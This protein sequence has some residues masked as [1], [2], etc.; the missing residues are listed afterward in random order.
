MILYRDLGRDLPYWRGAQLKRTLVASLDQLQMCKYKIFE[1]K[2]L[3]QEFTPLTCDPMRPLGW[4]RRCAILFV[5]CLTSNHCNAFL[6]SKSPQRRLCQGSIGQCSRLSAISQESTPTTTAGKAE[7][8]EYAPLASALWAFTRP[9]TIIGSALSI[10]ALH[11][12]ASPSG[13]P[14]FQTSHIL[15]L[16]FAWIPA[17]LLNIYIVGLNQLTGN[18]ETTHKIICRQ[19]I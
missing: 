4:M 10:P 14:A 19:P 17:I 16:L 9:H 18:L 5:A 8:V 12:F 7:S 2:N 1:N 13:S 6:Q 15:P 3:L 11:L